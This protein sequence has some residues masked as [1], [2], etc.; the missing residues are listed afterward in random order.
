[1]T[2]TRIGDDACL[3]DSTIACCSTSVRPP[4]RI[5][6]WS[7]LELEVASAAV[8]A[9]QCSVGTRSAKTTTRSAPSRADADLAEVRD[10]P[11][12]LGRLAA[13]ALR[14][15]GRRGA[16]ARRA[17]APAS[18]WRR[19]PSRG[20]ARSTVSR[21][22]AGRGQERL[23]QRPR[24]EARVVAG[25]R[26]APPAGCSQ[27]SASSS[28]IASSAGDRG[29]ERGAAAPAARPS[30]RRP[31]G[32]LGAVPVPADDEA[33]RPRPR[34]MSPSGVTAVGSSSRIS[35]AKDSFLPLCGVR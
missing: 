8:A 18:P 26:A 28:A 2:S 9:S 1:M 31:R 32:D 4:C 16:R 6:T 13:R 15:R 33:L 12:V 19:R 21:S 29:D 23:G 3:N 11:V 17:R 22:A 20:C 30:R 35:S 7:A 10:E 34:S 25:V 5:S 27:T 24:E 14:R